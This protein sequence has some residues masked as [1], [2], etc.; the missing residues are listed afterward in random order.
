[1]RVAVIG[2]GMIGGSVARDLAAG[3]H[4]VV[5]FDRS[6]AVL[7]AARR[8]GIIVPASGRGYTALASCDVCVIAVP[9]SAA[10]RLIGRLAGSLANVPLVTDV[11]STKRSIV[12]AAAAAGLGGR[13]V[14]AHP[15]AGDHRAGW[16]ASRPDRFRGATV[17]LTPTSSVSPATLRRARQFWRAL[18]GRPREL[19]A[20]QHDRLLA[21]ASH[22]PQ[23]VSSALGI[24][25][26]SAGVARDAL[27]PGGRDVSRLAGSD[28]RV[29][30]AIA[31]DNADQIVPVLRRY[32]RTLHRLCAAVAGGSRRDVERRLA[33]ANRWHQ[34]SE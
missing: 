27:G 33:L 20:A 29:W 31:I 7:R 14:G 6:A 18:G 10:S 26:A 28:R 15:L 11:G 16:H 30:S 13:F 23:L 25:L 5:G 21:A 12:R 3:G 19:S 4:E 22:L 8:A 17:F 1:V 9:V 32:A 2:L 24:T 34:A